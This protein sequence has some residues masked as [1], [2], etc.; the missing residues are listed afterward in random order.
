MKSIARGVVWWPNMDQVN[1]KAPAKA[2]LHIWKWPTTPWTRSHIDYTSPFLG[3]MFLV[4]VDSRSIWLEVEMVPST[5]A[6]NTIM[7]LKTIFMTHG[8]PE[9]IV[10]DYE[11]AF[12][13]VEFREFLGRNGIRHITSAP[14]HLASNGMV[15]R[16]VQTFKKSL[17][18]SSDSPGD[19]HR[20]LFQFLFH[21]RT[22]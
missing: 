21:Y 19:L 8:L 10:S 9:V 18:K 7:K 17:K 12:I 20:K 4:V 2:P 13:T 22:M 16:Y 1:Q 5:S 11:T 15:E 14:Y 6:S 3:E